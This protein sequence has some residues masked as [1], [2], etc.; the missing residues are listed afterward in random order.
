MAVDDFL[1]HSWSQRVAAIQADQAQARANLAAAQANGDTAAAGEAIE[2]IAFADQ[3]LYALANIQQ[4]YEASQQ[5][6]PQPNPRG[7]TDEQMEAARV[8]G[9]T[10]DEYA[11]GAI[12]CGR[13]QRFSWQ[14]GMRQR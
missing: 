8:C 10:P 4:R 7:L 3:R 13:Q 9:V 14:N 12:E 2:H 6:G 1:T 11:D 5:L